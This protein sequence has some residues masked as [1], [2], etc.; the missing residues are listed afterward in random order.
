MSELITYDHLKDHL[1]SI[2]DQQHKALLCTI[3]AGMARVG[4][5]VHGRYTKTKPLQAEDIKSYPNRIELFI[6]SEKGDRPRKV[7]IF[8]NRE[9]W[10]CDVIEDWC[11]HI[12]S[13]PLFSFST[14]WAER[15]FKQYFP[16]IIAKRG[17][18]VDGSKHT[19]HW[20]RGWRFSHY[21][22][23]NVT[24]KAVESKV[25]ALLGGWVSSAVPEK[26]YDFTKID[27]F[28]GV[29]ENEGETGN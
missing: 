29:L 20:L 19:I 16:D 6:K 2:G 13:G 10:L 1:L 14:R 17:G 3:Y 9:G 18:N 21:R 12:G 24:G 25:A 7:P 5:I 15:I 23:G 11:K 4:E 28:M 8:R 22:R 26:F 27:D